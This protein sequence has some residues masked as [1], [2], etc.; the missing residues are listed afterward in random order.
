[1]SQTLL[2]PSK[3]RSLEEYILVVRLL[4]QECLL[5]ARH[6]PWAHS[7]WAQEVKVQCQWA[8]EVKVQCQWAQAVRDLGQ[9]L[10]IR[11]SAQIPCRNSSSMV[12][13]LGVVNIKSFRPMVT[14]VVQVE[15]KVV[16]ALVEV[17]KALVEVC[18]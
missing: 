17:V 4:D 13:A 8:Q 16:K 2:K 12:L 9:R 1:M 18:P 7:R 3:P 6:N 14:T 10:T 5:M 11:A 15:V